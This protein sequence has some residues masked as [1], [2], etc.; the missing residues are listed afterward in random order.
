MTQY[1]TFDIGGTNLKYVLMD[2]TGYI[3]EKGNTPTHYEDLATFMSS[4]Y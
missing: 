3:I 4:M 1:L 2:K